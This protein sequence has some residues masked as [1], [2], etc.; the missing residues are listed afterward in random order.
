MQDLG[1][2]KGSQYS[3][4][5][6]INN[7]GQVVG[8]SEKVQYSGNQ[9]TTTDTA[10]LWQKGKMTSLGTLGGKN[11]SATAINDL[12]QVVGTADTKTSGGHVF[13]W[14]S[15]HGMQ[16]L[17]TL[18]GTGIPV[19]P[20]GINAASQIVGTGGLGLGQAW[21]WQNGVMQDLNNLIPAGSGWVLE[22]ATAINGSGQIVG[23][24]QMNGYPNLHGFLLTPSTTAALAQPA[25][26]TQTMST[27]ASLQPTASI[28]GHGVAGAA[29]MVSGQPVPPTGAII[30]SAVPSAPSFTGM[31]SVQQHSSDPSS[32]AL[33]PRADSRQGLDQVFA[34]LD[35]PFADPL[36]IELAVA[37]L[38]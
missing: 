37:R 1:T 7:S 2:L 22:S 5:S 27:A 9:T 23:W 17:G 35:S 30:V 21:L 26:S 3:R 20:L 16:D 8:T 15:T 25:T 32:S 13:L 31:T 38:S 12:G 29:F 19:E 24:G 36:G 4:A 28:L 33:A 34:D 18:F 10:F 11:S 6:A 14:D